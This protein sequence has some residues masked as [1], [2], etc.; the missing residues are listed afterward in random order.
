[1][2]AIATLEDTITDFG[3]V[4]EVEMSV[5]TWCICVETRVID[6]SLQP[7]FLPL[8]KRCRLQNKVENLSPSKFVR[9]A[10]KH[11]LV[12]WSGAQRRQAPGTAWG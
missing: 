6:I 2:N 1:M 9:A 3:R 4:K 7:G 10:C 8:K 5:A 11:G 12:E